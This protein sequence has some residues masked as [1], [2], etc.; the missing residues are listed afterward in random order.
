MTDRITLDVRTRLSWRWYAG[1]ALAR[2]PLP[3]A[4]RVAAWNLALSGIGFDIGGHVTPYTGRLE[5]RT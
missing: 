2:L 4:W 3:L 5:A 1:R